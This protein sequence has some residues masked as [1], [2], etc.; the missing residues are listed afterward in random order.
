MP[1]TTTLLPISKTGM[2]WRCTGE[3]GSRLAAWSITEPTRVRATVQKMMITDR[4]SALARSST[5]PGP[6]RLRRAL[7]TPASRMV[8]DIGRRRMATSLS[9][10]SVRVRAA[11]RAT[12]RCTTR[13]IT[14]ASRKN[15]SRM[16]PARS[17]GSP[18]KLTMSSM[19]VMAGAQA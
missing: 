12:A 6:C 17:S 7:Q 14:M 15:I 8:I 13:S 9:S 19:N 10:R 1:I 18:R 4:Q 16:A 11:K 5:E 3:P 2:V